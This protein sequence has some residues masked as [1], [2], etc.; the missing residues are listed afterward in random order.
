M[1]EQ[2][3][4][5]HLMDPANP[6]PHYRHASASLTRVQQWVMSTLVASLI[7]HLAAGLVIGS[8]VMDEGRRGSRIGLVIIAG[9]LGFV[10][11]VAALVIHQK[12]FPNWWLLLGP[13][14]GLVGAWIVFG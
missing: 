8:A 12:T 14:P 6:Q 7:L 4:R 10:A 5:R 2:P 1:A 3:R 9:I 11:I 13:V